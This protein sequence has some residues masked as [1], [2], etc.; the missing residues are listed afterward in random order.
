MFKKM[1]KYSSHEAHNIYPNICI[2]N[3]LNDQQ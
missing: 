3:N 2:I 1:V